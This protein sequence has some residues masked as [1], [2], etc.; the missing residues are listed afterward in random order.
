MTTRD[1][2]HPQQDHGHDGHDEA[3]R[4]DDL[5]FALPEPANL[6]K[7]RVFAVGGLAI[8]VL[9]AAVALGGIPKHKAREALAAEAQKGEGMPR[10]EVLVPKALSSTE[11]VQL[12]GSV[13]PLEETVLY[14]RATGYVR[15]W[16]FDMGDVV[17]EG[18]V[19]A[20]L[21]TPELDR[22]LAQARA[23][24]AKAEAGIIQAKATGD[25]AETELTRYKTLAEQGLASK[26]DLDQKNAD[27]LVGR[28][29]LKVAQANADAERANVARL[30]QLKAYSKVVAPFAGTI[31]A[32]NVDRGALVTTGVTTLFKIA[33]TDT[34]RVF[35]SVPQNVAPSVKAQMPAKVIVREF[36]GKP[37][38][39]IV[40]HV[41]G[42]LDSATRT[43]LTEVRVPN[44]EH[45]LLA[46]MYAQVALTLPMPHKI[47]EVPG[48]AVITDAKGVHVA[49]VDAS[50]K[51]HLVPVVIERDTGATIQI[52]S[53][54]APTDKVVKLASAELTEGRQVEVVA[55]APAGSASH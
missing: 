27:A 1:E 16:Y 53:G 24:E 34:V 8:A 12:P 30:V 52:A 36:P 49:I 31:T 39:G 42:A 51:V 10:V 23:S 7:T 41:A 19:L 35:L 3:R 54:L 33:A 26:Q 37:F 46:G 20:D 38:D 14:A 9:A 29:N 32:R 15:K 2:S 6:S 13:Q 5:G 40:A 21:D 17:K 50:N 4:T 28:A 45:T 11:A 47:V 55:V 25:K 22:E 48:T 44:P 43:M 18:E